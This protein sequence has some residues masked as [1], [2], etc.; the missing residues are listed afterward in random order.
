MVIAIHTSN[1]HGL[2]INNFIERS[3]DQLIWIHWIV[4]RPI[5]YHGFH[6]IASM[7]LTQITICSKTSFHIILNKEEKTDWSSEIGNVE[8]SITNVR[9]ILQIAQIANTVIVSKPF[10]KALNGCLLVA[11]IVFLNIIKYYKKAN[12]EQT[13]TIFYHL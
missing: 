6:K 12:F 13:P 10:W 3:E 8:P 4:C 11:E 1:G 7:Y 5:K 9:W 2:K